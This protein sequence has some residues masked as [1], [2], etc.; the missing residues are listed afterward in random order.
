M[1]HGFQGFPVPE[2]YF[3]P[4]L[5]VASPVIGLIDTTGVSQL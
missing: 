1:V 2:N 4:P 3:F 5:W